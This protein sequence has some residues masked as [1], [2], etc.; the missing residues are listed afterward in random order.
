MRT[1][2]IVACPMCGRS[3]FRELVSKE[4]PYQQHL[5]RC[6]GCGLVR[7]LGERQFQPDYWDDDA[8]ALD[9]YSDEELRAE[10]R[11]RYE[12]YLKVITR[13]CGG[14][15]SLLDVGCGIGEFL[16]AARDGGWQVAGVEVSEKAAM[17]AR[18]RGLEVET[19]H[20]EESRLAPGAFD[21]VTLWDVIE[22]LDAPVAAM[23][24]VHE[25]LKP[26]GAVFLETPNEGFGVR[27]A[28]RKAFTISHGRIDLLRYFYYPD[29]RF[30]FTV[31]TLRQLFESTGF[32]GVQVWRDVTSPTKA[33]RKI[34][35]WRF[36]LGRFV[37]PLLPAV[38]GLMRRF[39]MG[40]KLMVTAT[41]V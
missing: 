37:L 3:L 9:V 1:S 30:Y 12:R 4:F 36:P 39:G 11:R 41:K 20:L 2:S 15:G 27:S 33:R 31:A 22:H 25:K 29:H 26:G 16:L 23:R 28:F 7:L 8:V 18:S 32:Q 14:P 24:V 34:A 10:V 35:P 17:I 21:A 19:A 13:L 6:D 38:L 40:N 5:V